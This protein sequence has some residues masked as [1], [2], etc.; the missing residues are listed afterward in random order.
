MSDSI[1]KKLISAIAQAWN[2][3]A[4]SLLGSS[5]SLTL[6][7]LREVSGSGMP[8]ALAVATTWSSAIAATCSGAADGVV[9]ALFKYEEGEEI[10]RMATQS[11]DGLPRPGGRSLI[12]G[13][14][15]AAAASLAADL[16]ETIAFSPTV[17]IDL[18]ADE[19]RLATIVG[20]VAHI[21]TFS[22]SMGEESTSQALLLYAPQ[23]SLEGTVDQPVSTGPV[24]SASNPSE[25]K[26]GAAASSGSQA[27]AAT[28]AAAASS[29]P[30]S[31]KG[32]PRNIER[33]LDVELEV[34]VRF[35]ITNIPLRDVVRMGIGTMV[36]LN[37]AVE[38]PV[39]LLVNGRQLA[40]GEV[41][42]VDGYYG[43]RI[44]EIGSQSDRA[45][46]IAERPTY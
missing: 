23:G 13:V 41:V 44:T 17:Y 29:A 26:K 8:A 11:G 37:R 21:G 19:T 39:E 9:I 31:H 1:E 32:S 36:E 5:S 43:V 20:D 34:V 16:T 33:L 7:S 2:E 10:D 30:N 27:D 38:E 46:Q 40:R 3:H 28:L 12:T 42:V 4:P 18:S 24:S 15:D 35:G 22:L 14:L 6:L 25:Q 45:A